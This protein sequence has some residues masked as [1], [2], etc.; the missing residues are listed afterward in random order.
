[1]HKSNLINMTCIWSSNKQWR[2]LLAFSWADLSSKKKKQ[3]RWRI[4][5]VWETKRVV[6]VY[7]QKYMFYW[8]RSKKSPTKWEAPFRPPAH[9]LDPHVACLHRGGR[10]TGKMA[11]GHW[12]RPPRA[13]SSPRGSISETGWDKRPFLQSHH[14]LTKRYAVQKV[15]GV[16]SLMIFLLYSLS[17]FYQAINLYNTQQIIMEVLQYNWCLKDPNIVFH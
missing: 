4:N 17:N 14:M 16:F 6:L 11:P 2:N 5:G 13:A 3:I 10:I 12:W 15:D 7:K 1:M 8:T 9:F